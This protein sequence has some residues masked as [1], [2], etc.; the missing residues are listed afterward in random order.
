MYHAPF[1]LND[2]INEFLLNYICVEH[3]LCGVLNLGYIYCVEK[4][5]VP[6]PI[7]ILYL[8]SER[9]T[10][11]GRRDSGHSGQTTGTNTIWNVHI[12]LCSLCQ[13]VANE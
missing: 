4:N 13:G 2:P 8:L 9:S 3:V 11:C 6:V 7:I 1:R 12:S 5:V 10:R